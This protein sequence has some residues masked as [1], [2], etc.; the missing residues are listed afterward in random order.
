MAYLVDANVL[1]RLIQPSDPFYPTAFTALLTLRRCGE[2]LAIVPQTVFE[3]WNDCTRPASARGGYGLSITD[4]DLRVKRLERR[5]P[6]LPDGAALYT[7]WRSLVVAH[8]VQGVQVHD[9]RLVAAMH[10]HS[11]S[12]ILTFNTA[13]F[14]RYSKITAVHPSNV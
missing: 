1:L 5:Y 4:T 8:A 7:E 10:L 13:D 3:F 9:A 2:H 12:H 14:A 6:L 11:L